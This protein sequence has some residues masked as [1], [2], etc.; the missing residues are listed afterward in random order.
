MLHV[1]PY[2]VANRHNDPHCRCQFF[3]VLPNLFALL[4]VTAELVLL[5]HAM[6][7]TNGT[8]EDPICDVVANPEWK[9]AV[10]AAL[11]RF[12]ACRLA[13]KGTAMPRITTCRTRRRQAACIRPTA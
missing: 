10:G 9:F 12:T 2:L 5:L 7:G 11:W 13:R 8:T 4:S 1:S 3:D 6:M